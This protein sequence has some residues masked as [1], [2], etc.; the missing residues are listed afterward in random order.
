MARPSSAARRPCYFVTARDSTPRPASRSGP[1]RAVAERTH[2]AENPRVSGIQT[3]SGC[4]RAACLVIAE[5]RVPGRTQRTARCLSLSQSAPLVEKVDLGGRP[6]TARKQMRCRQFASARTAPTRSPVVQVPPSR[7]PDVGSPSEMK[8]SSTSAAADA[9]S[10]PRSHRTAR[11]SAG[12]A[13]AARPPSCTELHATQ[14][15]AR[16][17]PSM[18]A[19]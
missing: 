12:S 18:S 10:A 17:A 2:R 6:T 5:Q 16:P 9:A 1:P 19:H 13:V 14:P 11:G 8:Q 15:S 7:A 4:R 3:R